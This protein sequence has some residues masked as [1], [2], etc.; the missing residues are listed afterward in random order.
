M[1]EWRGTWLYS[2]IFQLDVGHPRAKKP[3]T[4]S[5]PQDTGTRSSVSNSLSFSSSPLSEWGR[6]GG[7]GGELEVLE[8]LCCN[9]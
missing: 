8:A 6:E 1:Q 5:Q 4:P 3:R 2:A 9:D 7:S